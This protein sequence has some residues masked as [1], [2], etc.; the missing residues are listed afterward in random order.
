[1][2]EEFVGTLNY[3]SPEVLNRAHNF[4]S[5]IWS[6]GVIAYILL[7]GNLPFF[8]P[9]DEKALKEKIRKGEYD[10]SDEIWK[11]ISLVGRKF[12]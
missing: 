6:C 9:N 1:M 11:H 3:C 7:S 2:H 8:E 10:F 5:D 4:K 12:I